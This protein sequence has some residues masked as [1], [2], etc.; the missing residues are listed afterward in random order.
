MQ[1]FFSRILSLDAG[2]YSADQLY[3]IQNRVNQ[4]GIWQARLE[5]AER[6]VASNDALS[7]YELALLKKVSNQLLSENKINEAQIFLD[8]IEREDMRN[9]YLTFEERKLV[10]S[11]MIYAPG[12]ESDFKKID[13]KASWLIKTRLFLRLAKSANP[14][15]LGEPVSYR[16]LD[17]GRKVFTIHFYYNSTTYTLV[18]RVVDGGQIYIVGLGSAENFYNKNSMQKRIKDSLK[19]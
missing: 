6:L 1:G 3:K 12:V 4:A 16:E 7:T 10:E 11:K 9:P 17:V 15:S 13:T 5:D 19:I 8:R 18:Y 2:I 14:T